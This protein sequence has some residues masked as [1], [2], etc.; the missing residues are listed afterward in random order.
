VCAIS[1]ALAAPF[2][3]LTVF[4]P[5]GVLVWASL[6]MSCLLLVMSTGPVNAQL[7]DVLQPWERG[8]GMSMA[9]LALHVIGDVPGVPLVGEISEWFGFNAAFASMAVFALLAGGVWWW[10]ALR[11][12][13]RIA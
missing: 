2:I 6:S 12:P 9:I 3:V 7:V 10:A 1:T 11:E 5:P 8:T 13:P 4:A